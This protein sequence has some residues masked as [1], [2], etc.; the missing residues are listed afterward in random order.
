MTQFPVST[1][2]VPEKGEVVTGTEVCHHGSE[3]VTRSLVRV[4]HDGG[5][6]QSKLNGRS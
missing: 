6:E 4:T 3:V 1:E 2:R 5:D